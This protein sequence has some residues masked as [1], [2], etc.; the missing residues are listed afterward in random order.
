[1]PNF[2]PRF[3]TGFAKNE[4]SIL[5]PNY[6][7]V[8]VDQVKDLQRQAQA[9]GIDYEI[10]VADD[11]SPDKESIRANEVINQ[12]PHCRYIVKG[13]NSG[14]AATRN[15]LGASSRYKWMLFLDADICIPG[16]PFLRNYL[17]H[18]G[19][20]VINGGISIVSNDSLKSNL[21]YIYEKEAEPLHSA[22]RRQQNRY[23]EFRS[24]NFLIDRASFEQCP[25]DERFTKSGYED[26]LFGKHLKQKGIPVTHIDNPVMMKT[27]ESNPDYVTKTERNLRTLHQFRQELRGYSRMLTFIEGIHIPLIL[28]IIRL[29]HR[30]FGSLIRRNLCSS[31]PVLRLFSLYRLGYFLAIDA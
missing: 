25:F 24:T 19:D 1:M 11:A 17:Q 12:L 28:F 18:P 30:L 4:L 7:N 9:L 29:F 16:D 20:G 15:F 23:Q 13:R 21:R 2:A 6:N 26:V 10:I 3:M 8:C 5:I 31:H 14:S 27:F 22:D